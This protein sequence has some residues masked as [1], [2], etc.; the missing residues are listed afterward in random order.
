MVRYP[1]LKLSG[2]ESQIGCCT[3][4]LLLFVLE[5]CYN[6]YLNTVFCLCLNVPTI[7]ACTLL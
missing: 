1:C 7:C 5:L 3:I 2:D 6:F 4:N